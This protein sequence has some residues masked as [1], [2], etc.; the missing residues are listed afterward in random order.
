MTRSFELFK[1]L[2]FTHAVDRPPL[3]VKIF[4]EEDVKLITEFMLNGYF[5]HFKLY[6]YIFT[7][8]LK[9]T[10]VQRT[11][12]QIEIPPQPRPLGEALPLENK[13]RAKPPLP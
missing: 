6:K 7:K 5:R 11:P 4:S 12:N 9:V 3:F 1:K 8:K 13:P 10:L 2:M